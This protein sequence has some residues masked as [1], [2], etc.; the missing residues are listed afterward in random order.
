MTILKDAWIWN[1]MTIL[2]D[3]WVWNHMTILKDAWIWNHMTI[4]KDAWIWNHMTILEDAWIWN[5]MT[6]LKDAWIWN[7]G[8]PEIALCLLVI[9]V[10]R[11]L[12]RVDCRVFDPPVWYP[13]ESLRSGSWMVHGR[14]QWDYSLGRLSKCS[15]CLVH[16]ARQRMWYGQRIEPR[17]P[18]PQHVSTRYCR[19]A[20]LWRTNRGT[21]AVG[22]MDVALISGL[23]SVACAVPARTVQ[24]YWCRACASFAMWP[25]CSASE[26]PTLLR[27]GMGERFGR[28]SNGC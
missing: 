10:T 6:I 8:C 5:H 23:C 15:T 18:K 4:L 21:E 9:S 17:P 11:W 1:H 2:K 16:V 19:D 12:G 14:H 20:S 26:S 28:R 22:R 3:A 27:P 25:T 13:E 24:R 7:H